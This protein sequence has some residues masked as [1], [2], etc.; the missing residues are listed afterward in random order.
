VLLVVAVGQVTLIQV[1][2][3]VVELLVILVV[4]VVDRRKVEVL[5]GDIIQMELL[6]KDLVVLVQHMEHPVVAVVE[7]PVDNFLIHK[8][9]RVTELLVF[10]CLLG[11]VL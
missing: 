9:K 4:L 11:L 3:V 5:L 10:K 8:H 6:D 7:V 1:Q 2:M